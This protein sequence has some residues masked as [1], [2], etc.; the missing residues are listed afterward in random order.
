MAEKTELY[1]DVSTVKKDAS[2]NPID[3]T[4]RVYEF[5]EKKREMMFKNAHIKKNFVL[6][7]VIEPKPETT[8]NDIES[9]PNLEVTE[10]KKKRGRK[11]KEETI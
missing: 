5:T 6:L 3:G 10:A 11:P 8:N 9:V 1:L 4:G 7:E 2:G